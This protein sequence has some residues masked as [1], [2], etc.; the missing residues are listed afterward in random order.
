MP[1][2]KSLIC[3]ARNMQ[4]LSRLEDLWNV[5]YSIRDSKTSFELTKSPR[6]GPGSRLNKL[7]SAFTSAS[8][9]YFGEVWV[10]PS[11]G[12]GSIYKIEIVKEIR[13][14]NSSNGL[15][16]LLVVCL[17]NVNDDIPAV[18]KFRLVE[19]ESEMF[20]ELEGNHSLCV[21]FDSRLRRLFPTL[22]CMFDVTTTASGLK[23][24]CIG[25]QPLVD[26]S[27]PDR[28]D[29]SVLGQCAGLIRDIHRCGYAHGDSHLGNFMKLPADDHSAPIKVLMID[30]DEIKPLPTEPHEIGML[31][32]M[33]IVDYHTLL[34]HFNV[35]C[36]ALKNIKDDSEAERVCAKLFKEGD[37]F[38]MLFMPFPYYLRHGYDADEIMMELSSRK[39]TKDSITYLQYLGMLE[40]SEIDSFFAEL[41]QSV[42]RMK[43][44]NDLIALARKPATNDR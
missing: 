29:L 12:I 41:L 30:Q 32:Y 10:N 18:L 15:P 21:A 13:V 35:Y 38:S 3:V 31:N 36:Q 20:T 23:W 14:R 39:A 11:S 1:T 16:C 17:A 40:S 28:G 25:M 24:E 8:P 42:R 22:Y 4:R 7:F 19:P 27:T 33:K 2:I 44:L 6:C 34:F 26:L 37:D 9:S 43:S 5:N